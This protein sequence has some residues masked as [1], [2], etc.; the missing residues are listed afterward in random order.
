VEKVKNI[1]ENNKKFRNLVLK[2]FNNFLDIL[3]KN[4]LP[5]KKL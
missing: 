1:F 2:T 3:L 5:A 4:G